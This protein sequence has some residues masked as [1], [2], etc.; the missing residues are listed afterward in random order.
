MPNKT[1]NITSTVKSIFSE[2]V[3]LKVPQKISNVLWGLFN[4]VQ[5][6]MQHLEWKIDTMIRERNILTATH[7]SSLRSLAA[8]NGFEPKLKIPSQGLL[9]LKIDQSLYNRVGYPLFI[10][11]YAEFKCKENGMTYYY[12][13]DTAMRLVGSSYKIP[14]VE[15]EIRNVS[16]NATGESIQR[17]YLSDDSI[18]NNSVSIT[19][20]N[21][22]FIEVKSFFDNVNLNDNK[23]FIIK[24]SHNPQTPIIIYVKGAEVGDV[25]NIQYRTTY[26]EYGNIDNYSTFDT[27]D[28]IDKNGEEISVDDDEVTITSSFGFT[29]GSNGTDIN[30]LK[31]A[32]GYNHGSSLLFD[33]IT[34]KN[35]INGFSTL[36]LQNIFVDPDKRSINRIYV[37][38]KQCMNIIDSSI[39]HEYKK[40]IENNLYVLSK[41]NKDELSEILSEHE[42]CLIS[43]E[44]HDAVT[45]KYA[46]QIMFET[47]SD[48]DYHQSKISQLIYKEF[49]KFLYDK[50]HVFYFDDFIH[51]YEV[52]NGI[53]L[54]YY[55]FSSND[56]EYNED[57]RQIKHNNYLPI[58]KGDF[59]ITT[60]DGDVIQ[61]FSD[62][63]FVIKN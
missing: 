28:I 3:S 6:V 36:L 39:E 48:R 51:N 37:S 32:I 38:K 7:K 43:H 63:N 50:N 25:L 15:G 22:E 33:Q 10:P 12:N 60:E 59:G 11:P 24:F 52:D 47:I 44:I 58:L 55:I 2:F 8:E 9:S 19:S 23:Q 20:N 41:S 42:H 35:F 29:L 34:Y 56:N 17:I 14:V 18:A 61:L 27:K 5:A 1:E 31:S 54:E 46:F 16:E 45:C 57:R 62:I 49:A 26:G 40:V 53:N 13:S 21:K 30:A 4:G